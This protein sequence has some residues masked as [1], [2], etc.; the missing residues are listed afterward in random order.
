MKLAL[1]PH[2]SPA[3]ILSGQPHDQLDKLVRQRWS[4]RPPR[5]AT[6]PPPLPAGQLPLPAQQGG[7]GDQEG[8]PP[9]P[10]Q[11]PTQHCQQCAVGRPVD[12]P[13]GHLALQ[14]AQLVTQHQD[15]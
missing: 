3:W 12:H 15:L 11:Q 13:A 4:A 5:P 8:A 10:G 7:R 6:P 2:T 9:H 1:D 14:H